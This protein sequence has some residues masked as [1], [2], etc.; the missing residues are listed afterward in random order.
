MLVLVLPLYRTYSF[1]LLLYP[2]RIAFGRRGTIL[3]EWWGVKFSGAITKLMYCT[4]DLFYIL[5]CF[6]K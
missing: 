4:V 2:W 6:V 3:K 5:G 1:T